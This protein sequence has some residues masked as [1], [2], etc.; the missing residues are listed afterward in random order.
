MPYLERPRA[1]RRYMGNGH[2]T[3]WVD[4][5]PITPGNKS[6]F[7]PQ[8]TYA[9][10]IMNHHEDYHD[11]AITQWPPSERNELRFE[12]GLAIHVW[13]FQADLCCWPS[14]VEISQADGW[15]WLGSLG[16]GLFN[17]SKQVRRLVENI[18]GTFMQPPKWSRSL[19]FFFVN[20]FKIYRVELKLKL[21]MC[22]IGWWLLQQTCQLFIALELEA[23]RAKAAV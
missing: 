16:G 22:G 15:Y 1:K 13:Q 9:W 11:T 20:S 8:H 3:Y 19:S 5:Y 2:L 6:E 23:A 17:L 21:R 4:D 7:R 14:P 12:A 18:V 10:Y